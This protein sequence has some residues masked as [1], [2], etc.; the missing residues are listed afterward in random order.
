MRHVCLLALAA[1]C[2][3][4]R[5]A[6]PLPHVH[7]H[8]HV[9][10][11]FEDAQEWAQTFDDPARDEWQQPQEVVRLLGVEPG[12][13]VVDLGAGTGYFLSHL[14]RAVGERGRVIALDVE[15]SMVE[16]MRQRVEREGLPNVEVRLVAPDDPGLGEATVNK[17]LIVDTWHHIADRGAYAALLRRAL[18][19]DGCTT[20][21]A[22]VAVVDY[23]REAP[24]GPPPEMRLPPEAVQDDLRRGSLHARL[25]EE[26]LPRQY[27]IP[28]E[29]K[30]RET[31]T[32]L[33][34]STA[35]PGVRVWSTTEVAAGR[36]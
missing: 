24:E 14:S 35:I 15:P 6:E 21:A 19:A 9:G 20:S 23:T 34:G 31:V 30:I 26:A 29:M 13:V 5:P 32:A 27:V 4:P 3:A 10:H 36:R 1:G 16:H 18:I 33:K 17:I 22:R 28:N 25:L 2:G 12:D 11:R 8:A 7:R